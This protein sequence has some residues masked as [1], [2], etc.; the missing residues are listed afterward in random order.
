MAVAA[1]LRTRRKVMNRLADIDRFVLDTVKADPVCR[2]LMTV[3]GLGAIPSLA[4][5]SAVEDPR[6]FRKSTLVGVPFGLTPGKYASGE[7]DRNGRITKCGD[8]MVRALLSE[9]VNAPLTRGSRWSW[10]K[11][12]G[13]EVMRRR[14]KLRG[15]TTVAPRLAVTMHRMWMDATAFL[16]SRA[17]DAAEVRG[18]KER[19]S[20]DPPRRIRAQ[21]TWSR[22]HR[23]TFCRSFRNRSGARVYGD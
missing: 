6:R 19:T 15:H 9:A 11:R 1:I 13:V 7:T 4:Y 10:L 18:P 2:P 17:G 14:G 12:W 22:R 21:G 16:E 8:R 5:R 3:P 20:R 23:P